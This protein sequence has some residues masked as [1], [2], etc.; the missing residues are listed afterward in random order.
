MWCKLTSSNVACHDLV[1]QTSLT[2]LQMENSL[3]RIVFHGQSQLSRSLSRR[4]AR[5]P[6]L[7]V[8]MNK[9]TPVTD[10]WNHDGLQ[11]WFQWFI[12]AERWPSVSVAA[13]FLLL[14]DLSHVWLS[15]L[16]VLPSEVFL[17]RREMDAH[18]W[19]EF[20]FDPRRKFGLGE[21]VRN[22]FSFTSPWGLRVWRE[23]LSAALTE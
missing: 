23:V 22:C 19:P 15:P 6:S 21:S 20:I 14:F 4:L 5:S 13:V 3:R 17:F 18:D 9:I 7:S 10:W 12:L 16:A 8:I 11:G 2:S 1:R